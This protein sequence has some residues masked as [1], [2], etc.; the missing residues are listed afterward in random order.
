MTNIDLIT[1]NENGQ[2][3]IDWESLESITSLEFVERIKRH[4]NSFPNNYIFDI[5]QN[6]SFVNVYINWDNGAL[7]LF[8]YYKRDSFFDISICRLNDME[9]FIEHLGGKI[10]WQN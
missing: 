4:L 6:T 8:T 5:K 2:G 10:V 7:R 9:R 3:V 1:F